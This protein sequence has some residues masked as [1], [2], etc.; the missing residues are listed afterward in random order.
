MAAIDDNAVNHLLL[1]A[2]VEEQELLLE[3]LP[4][5]EHP[6]A[7]QEEEPLPKEEP[8]PPPGQHADDEVP[9]SEVKPALEDHHDL[10]Q[11]SCYGLS[12]LMKATCMGS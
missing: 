9:L 8:L 10:C 7:M 11:G 12:A 4:K 3:P 5:E 2:S 6:V 1:L